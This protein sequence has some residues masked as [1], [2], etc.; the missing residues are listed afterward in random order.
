MSV[1]ISGPKGYDYQYLISLLIALEYLNKDDVELYI[2]KKNGEDAQILLSENGVQY[3][4]DIQVKSKSE[5]IS[6]ENLADWISHFE[7]LSAEV[8]LLNKVNNDERRFALFVTNSR[9]NDDVSLF[10][11]EGIIHSELNNG[12][13]NDLLKKI[14]AGVYSCY[15]DS[16]SLSVSRK[17]SL[18]EFLDNTSL[19]RFRNIMKKIKLRE[20][21][22]EEYARE[23][24][25]KLLNKKYYIPQNTT[26]TVVTELIEEIRN[27]RGLGSS[28]TSKLI[29]VI[30]RYSGKNILNKD[31]KYIA[32]DEKELCENTL[33]TKNVLLLTG[34]SFCGKSFLAKDIAQE[35]MNVGYR[36]ELIGEIYGEGGAIS[37]ISHR[38]IEDR[39][40]IIEDPFGQVE[41]KRDAIA[42]LNEIRNLIRESK[43]NRKIIITSR[44][45]ILQDIMSK[46]SIDECSIDS[47]N[48]IDLTLETSDKALA[49]WENYLGD[50]VES[51]GLYERIT[52]W[53][54]RTEKTSSLQLGHIANIYN[55]KKDLNELLSLEPIDII[56]IARI[57]SD[58]L[59][60]VIEGRGTVSTKVFIALGLSCNTYKTVNLNDL[61]FILSDS[62]DAPGIR[63][64][65]KVSFG[66]SI[67]HSLDECP[68]EAFPTYDLAVKINDEQKSVLK[69][70]NQH[71]YIE[72]DNL[73]RIKF[74]HPIYH[75]ATQLLFQKQF[76]DIFEQ[77]EVLKIAKQSLSSLS[78]S[79]NLSTL[80]MLEN[81]YIENPNEE[82]K[83]LLLR[84]LK[85]IFP[86]V[87]DRVIMF[88]DRRINDL[89]ESEQENFVN[90]LKYGE[91]IKNEGILWYEGIP[92]FN[93]SDKREFSY[94]D[95]LQEKISKGEID[96]LLGKI[97]SKT[98]LSSE[99]MWNLIN[100]RNKK[101]IT[102]KVLEQALSY[103]ESFIREK[104]IRLIF[105]KY[106]FDFANLDEYL[107]VY[108]HP[109]VI[110][111]LFRGALDSWSKYSNVAKQ[112]IT[113]YFINSLDI[114]SV[115]I[116]SKK[117]LENFED[118]HS[119]DGIDWSKIEE[120]DK[121][122]LW[123]VWHKV[124]TE[125]FNK[126]PS[127][128]IQMNEPHMVRVT[129]Y[130]LKY[131]NSE[132]KVVELA[133]AWF[134]WLNRYLQYNLPHDY[135][136]SVSQYLMNGTLNNSSYREGIVKLM[137]S[138]EKTS[139]VTS[140]VKEFIDSWNYLSD[141]EKVLVNDLLSSNR[142]D[143][144]WIKAVALNRRIIP[145]EIQIEILGEAIENKDIAKIVDILI[146]KEILEQCLN[147]HCGYPQPLWWNGY[148][149]NNYKLWDAVIVEILRRNILDKAFDI[150]LREL[151]DLI[152]NYDNRRISNI[153]DIYIDL[154]KVKEK[155]KL[156]FE[157]LLY[158]TID[159][160]QC[161]KKVWDL[162]FEHSSDDE[163]ENYYDKI[164]DNIELVQCYQLNDGDLFALFSKEIIF[165]KLLLMVN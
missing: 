11:D 57:D 157:R 77:E 139:F 158:D 81:V 99:E 50:S 133:T 69:Y 97:D 146:K 1:E 9:C 128:Y 32:R 29:N 104:A 39:L 102:L 73:K 59:A 148:H 153:Y 24:C 21:Y 52:N 98:T 113:E 3:T 74:V 85:S 41:T 23:K 89:N 131:I 72:I 71:G 25:N 155:R 46:K 65:E 12:L 142:K 120:E 109:D 34:V 150:A 105:E 95:W 36:V 149:H 126:F 17:K 136:M 119:S 140:N 143:V 111:S 26:D 116:R 27:G 118:E 132:E 130:S 152:Y 90:I 165:K 67:E 2:E 31:S 62:S 30:N 7:N 108:E 51:K 4:I 107:N 83:G 115:C 6:L 144:K 76:I 70:L 49:L 154:L 137:L 66:F 45:D 121:K 43:E 63:E 134:N 15:S 80:S 100:L 82:L 79:S 160:N 125:F 159:Q 151:I 53:L 93:P 58:D 28:I 138:T 47:H 86:S 38:S 42:I 101:L 54:V 44:K 124:F 92:W 141:N 103:D 112:Q 8:S 117:F 123:S 19:K 162:L 164:V 88:F 75:Y 37:F 16:N 96:S 33:K 20:R 110:Y 18:K 5:D 68:I 114:M 55:S 48:W 147:V 22:T 145:S 56:N 35:Y 129:D 13:N 60:K 94:R 156:V 106:A 135:G 122:I 78:I 127:R 161:N 14:K 40:L 64:G 84:S 91:S 61:A 163:K 10:I 87:Q